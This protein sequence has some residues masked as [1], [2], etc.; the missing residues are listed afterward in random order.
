M[1]GLLIACLKPAP[2]EPIAETVQV[3]E[4][5]HVEATIPVLEARLAANPQDHEAWL[6]LARLHAQAGRLELSELCAA[7]AGTL[8]PSPDLHVDRGVAELGR[9]DVAAALRDFRSALALDPAHVDANMNLGILALDAGDF[10]EAAARFEAVLA[11]HPGHPQAALGLEQ[12]RLPA[13]RA[14]EAEEQAL[15]ARRQAERQ[16]REDQAALRALL[17]ELEGCDPMVLEFF[18]EVVERGEPAEL[19]GLAASVE[20]QAPEEVR[21][22]MCP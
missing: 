1:L 11:G 5:V 20:G 2:P 16:A 12:A 22:A 21:A 6:G 9:G 13:L 17:A 8:A 3:V 7:R 4:I 19:R 14:Q 15:L 10:S 18:S